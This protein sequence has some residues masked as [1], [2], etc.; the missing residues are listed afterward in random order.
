MNNQKRKLK[1]L[2]LRDEGYHLLKAKGDGWPPRSTNARTNTFGMKDIVF[3]RPKV[4]D[5]CSEA[6]VRRPGPSGK[7]INFGNEGGG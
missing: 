5:G 6:Q 2:D 1:D 3:V 7:G 4:M